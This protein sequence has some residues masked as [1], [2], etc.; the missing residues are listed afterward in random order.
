MLVKDI[1][2]GGGSSYPDDLTNVGRHAVLHADD[3]THGRELWKTD[4]TA[5]GTVL[6]KDI[7]PGRA[8]AARRTPAVLADERRTAR[9]SS[10][11]TTARPAASCGRAT[12][13]PPAPS[14]VK[15]IHPGA[16]APAY[17][18]PDERERHAVLHRPTTARPAQELWKTDGT[19]AGTVLVKDINPAASDSAIAAEPDGRQRHAVLHRQ[20][21]RDRQRAVEDRRH[22]RRHRARQ[23]H[24]PRHRSARSPAHLTNVDGTLFFA[25][26]RR[27][28]PAAS[29]GRATAPP[30]AP[31][32]SRTSTPAPA[33]RYPTSLTNVNG[34]LFFT[35]RRRHHGD[36]LWKSDGTAAGTVLVK[37]INPGRAAS[38]TAARST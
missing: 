27:H 34:T 23:G 5:A 4:G 19:A 2:A 36:E 24:Q 31:S 3:G 13:P 17:Q 14:L 20:R 22:R 18:V 9:C 11:P 7:N 26:Q 25:R 21:R 29:C 35:R 12:A 10:P 37:D 33:A 30:P 6:V 28:A 1:N 32:W 15:D 38:T 8:T 16:V